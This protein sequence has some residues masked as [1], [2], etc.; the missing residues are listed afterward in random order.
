MKDY[1]KI[2]QLAYDTLYQEYDKRANQKS[3][4]EESAETLGG[5]VL[6]C[7]KHR[8]EHKLALEVGPGSGEILNFFEEN[9][10]RTVAVELST[11]IANIAKSRS[12]RTV[13]ILGDIT[14][15]EFADDQFEIIYAGALIHLFPLDDALELLQ[16]FRK[17]LKPSGILF[18]NTTINLFSE[19]G[20]YTKT[21]YGLQ[22]KRF[23]RKWTEQEF[24]T[25]L[26]NIGFE[27]LERLFT[28][29]QDREKQ[30]VAFLC[31]KRIF[32]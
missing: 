8:F 32:K 16:K 18:V 25:K 11:K 26:Q 20:Y 12:P 13:F 2:N 1:I 15:I 17:W 24:L 3:K 10:C 29:E 4:F 28:D 7:V 23:R 31:T 21:D 14:E 6:N 19:E 9:G 27:I 5:A 22:V 30:W